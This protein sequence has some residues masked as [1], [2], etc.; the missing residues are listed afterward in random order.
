MN[1]EVV[2]LPVRRHKLVAPVRKV[3]GDQDVVIGVS[4]GADSVALLLLCVAGSLQESAQY[5][6][7][8]GHIHHGLRADSD[9][10]QIFVETLCKNLGV[11]CITKRVTVSPINGSLAAG[12]RDARYE[13]L[14][15]IAQESNCSA[16]A[17]A[18]HAQDQLETMLMALCRGGGLRK[19]SGIA[20]A[21]PLSPDINLFRPL[22]HVEKIE[23]EEICT[24]ANT[25]W[26]QDPTN[27]DVSTPRGRLRKDVIPV[28]RELWNASDRHAANAS[29]LLH[30]AADVFHA[31]VLDGCIWNRDVLAELPFPIINAT[32]Q[33]AI[34]ERA[35]F[36]TI[37]SIS[38]A[39]IDSNTNARTFQLKD[40]WE[41]RITSK[42]VSVVHS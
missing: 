39:V 10:E 27:N 7:V 23:L 17:V 33:Q 5:K 35:T 15:A 6:I 4:G 8:A 3:I 22:L 20:L 25:Q 24:L 16:V 34:G 9:D 2:P 31:S 41:T 13:A 37:H 30:A 38:E 28:L 40:G 42:K 36:E 19:L 18:H 14:L 21:R 12:A 1:K 26:C 32:L 29:T 11:E